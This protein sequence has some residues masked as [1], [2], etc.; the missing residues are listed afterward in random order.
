MN[1]F[2]FIRNL[3]TLS[4]TCNNY[5][6]T[7]KRRF[8][9]KI[10][11]KTESKSF[12]SLAKKRG[13]TN[14]TW[15]QGS[16]QPAQHINTLLPQQRIRHTENAKLILFLLISSFRSFKTKDVEN[17]QRERH[18]LLAVNNYST[19]QLSQY[20]L[21]NGHNR[22]NYHSVN[23]KHWTVNSTLFWVPGTK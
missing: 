22:C 16:A 7:N 21:H 5:C 6:C 15:T 1:G 19:C 12:L 17:C 3:T 13:K 14:Q 23:T 18:I 4:K 2:N 10:K 20:W 11:L 9:L 8:Y